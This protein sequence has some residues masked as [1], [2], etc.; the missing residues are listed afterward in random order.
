MSRRSPDTASAPREDGAHGPDRR[1]PRQ[2]RVLR[3]TSELASIRDAWLRLQGDHIVADPDFFAA[4]QLDPAVVRP[5]IVVLDRDGEPEAILVARIEQLRLTS[6]LGNRT[7]YAPEVRSIS[8]VNGGILG[9]VDE[10][11]FRQVLASF[12]ASLAQGEADVAL[13]RHLQID[14]PFYRIAATEVPF[15]SRQHVGD[16]EV[17]WALDLPDSLEDILQSRS[18]KT[19]KK[20]RWSART[21]ERTYEGRLVVRRYTRPE[22]ID[23]FF[24]DVEEVAPKT[25]Q[26]AFGL[27]LHDTP[28][29]RERTRLCLERGWFR[30]YVLA[31][32]GRPCSFHWGELYR[33]RFR[34]GRPGYDPALS[35]L[36]VGTYLLL[37]VLD[38]LC[39]DK[40]ARVVD[41]GR[42]DDEYKQRFGTRSWFE[43]NVL[44]YAPTLRG[45]RMNLTRTALQA[46]LGAA[47]RVAGHGGLARSMKKR[48]R[49]RARRPSAS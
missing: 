49:E 6:R 34:L 17:H 11:A 8:V 5:H 19:R 15:L 20:L 22:D 3:S 38:D 43:G 18:G 21:L 4:S 48:F 16:S 10:D 7:V 13:L 26:H 24:R 28:V 25:Y 37:Q 40:Q 30:G 36:S 23:D 45:A 29:Q 33:G 41:F 39:R 1:A 47:K 27:A 44:I 46:G 2:L 32:D 14:S 35:H 31:V 42:G 12:R 9:A